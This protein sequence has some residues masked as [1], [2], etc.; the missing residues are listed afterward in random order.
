MRAST[1]K[2]WYANGL[3]FEC[4]RCGHCCTGEPGYVRVS[5]EEVAGLAELVSLTADAFRQR[6]TRALSDGSVSLLE[7][8]TG[9][10]VLYAPERGCTVY[11]RRPLQCRSWPF[12][13]EVVATPERWEAEAKDCP[14]MNRGRLREADE[15]RT[16]SEN[17]GTSA[18]ARRVADT[19]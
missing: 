16:I 11:R 5:D 10:C 18:T 13:S 2:P 3:R 19:S 9:G 8:P 14:G 17:D 4:T 1:G 12:W 6:Y 15:I 7:T